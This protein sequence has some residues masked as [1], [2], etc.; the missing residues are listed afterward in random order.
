[1]NQAHAIRE[2]YVE[3]IHAISK[4]H[5]RS[6]TSPAY[7]IHPDATFAQCLGYTQDFVV[8]REDDMQHYRYDIYREALQEAS[9]DF[10]TGQ[11]LVHVDV[12]CGPGLFTW[13]VRDYFRTDQRIDLELYGYDHSPKMTELA[14]LIWN[15]LG[16]NT[17]YSCHHRIED[18]YSAAMQGGPASRGV[19]VTFGHVLIQTIDNEP[20]V[21]DFA[22]IIETFA[23]L[24]ECRILA[25]DARSGSSRRE[26]FRRACENLTRAIEQR[27][28]ITAEQNISPFSRMFARIGPK[29]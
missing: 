25:V 6:Y 5:E 24:G 1:M 3:I 26:T 21:S 19:L 9:I 2:R 23:R 10:K 4:N 8:G 15:R 28:I 14:N 16:E 13:V 7:L 27:G 18:L 22:S 17:H 12:G 20:A 29:V 11:T